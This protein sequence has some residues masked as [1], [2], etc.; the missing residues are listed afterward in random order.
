MKISL[1]WLNDYVDIS[2]VTAGQL[3]EKLFSCGFEVEEVVKINENVNKIVTC[4]IEEKTQHPA[5]DKL[6]VCRVNA[7]KYGVLQIVTN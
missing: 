4:R 7:G 2:S 5:A 6:F 1:K 3:E